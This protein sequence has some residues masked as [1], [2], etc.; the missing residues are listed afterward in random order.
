MN[1]VVKEWVAKAQDDFAVAS[2]EM[3]AGPRRSNDAVCFHAQQCVE[4]L[5][6]AL[7][8]QLGECPPKKHDLV[9]L[10]SLLSARDA[11]WTWNVTELRLLNQGAVDYRYLGEGA[12]AA[13]AREAMKY[14]RKLRKTL[15]SRLIP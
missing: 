12:E 1:S 15:M 7:L 6:K 13:D 2:R 4:K 9:V 10:D 14:A 8:I 3:R 11:S 5:M